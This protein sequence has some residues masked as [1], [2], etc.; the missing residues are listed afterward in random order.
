MHVP[1]CVIEN[2]AV[3]TRIVPT[4]DAAAAFAVTRKLTVALPV[5]VL[6]SVGV[7]QESDPAGDHVQ[8]DPVDTEKLLVA[9][10]AASVLDVGDTV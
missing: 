6:V 4:R 7:T 3:P 1:F 9:A 8:V 5:R 2:V 10:V